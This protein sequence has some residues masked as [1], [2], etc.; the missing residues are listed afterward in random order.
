MKNSLS[1]AQYRA[2]RVAQA[3]KLQDNTR[4]EAVILKSTL[5]ER[6]QSWKDFVWV[7]APIEINDSD[8]IGKSVNNSANF[9]IRAGIPTVFSWLL[10]IPL[11]YFLY[12]KFN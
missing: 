4:Q 2:Q 3:L 7:K 10:L 11:I 6:V 12:R 9:G 1:P 8:N 5:T